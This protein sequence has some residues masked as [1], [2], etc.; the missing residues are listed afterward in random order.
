MNKLKEIFVGWKNLLFGNPQT[1][2]M[3]KKRME[4]CSTCEYASKSV[5]LHCDK[6]GCYIPAKANSVNSDCPMGLWPID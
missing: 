3:A 6:C 1:K 5:Y 2:E 4:V